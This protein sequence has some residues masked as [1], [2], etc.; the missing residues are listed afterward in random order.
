MTVRKINIPEPMANCPYCLTAVSYASEDVQ[1]PAGGNTTYRVV[2]C[3]GC[4]REIPVPI[5][6]VP[7]PEEL[8]PP[9]AADLRRATSEG[10]G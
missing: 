4:L 7:V 9:K 2:D 1:L 6:P 10:K 8:R 5:P 3:P